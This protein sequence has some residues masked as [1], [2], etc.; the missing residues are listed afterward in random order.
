MTKKTTCP[1][2]FNRIP[3]YITACGKVI[4]LARLRRQFRCLKMDGRFD[5]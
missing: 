3:N 2:R 5:E 4:H 1:V